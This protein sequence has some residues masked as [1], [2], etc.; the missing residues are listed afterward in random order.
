MLMQTTV[1]SGSLA[2]MSSIIHRITEPGEYRGTVY[3]GTEKAGCF[4]LQVCDCEEMTNGVLPCQVTIDLL[5]VDTATRPKP[6]KEPCPFPMRTGGHVVFFVSTGPGEYAVEIYRRETKKEPVKVFDSRVLDRGDIF[7]THVLRP[8]RYM[9][10]NTK[11]KGQADLKVEYPE[12]GKLTP[13]MEPVLV[14]CKDGIIKPAEIKIQPVQGIMFSCT[15]P[16]RI[17]IELKKAEDRPRPTRPP[18]TPPH[19]MLKKEK[20]GPAGSRT[21]LRKIRFSG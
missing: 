15:Q 17:T 11:G 19:A 4:S 8:G 14:E 5:T 20:S 7:V 18:V 13:K 2:N 21:I 12:P 1:D 3:R 16:A 9:I 6:D 10:R